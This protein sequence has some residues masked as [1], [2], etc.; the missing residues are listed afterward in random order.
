[1]FSNN[2]EIIK[3]PKNKGFVHLFSI[4]FTKEG[5]NFVLELPI[6]YD[7]KGNNIEITKEMLQK[8]I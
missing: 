5:E 3:I 2:T 6:A 8:L 4:S 1:M 7:F